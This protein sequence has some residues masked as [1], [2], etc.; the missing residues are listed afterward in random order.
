[1]RIFLCLIM[2]LSSFCAAFAANTPEQAVRDAQRAIDTKNADRF[3]QLVDTKRIAG[4]ATDLLLAE[5]NKTDG[6]LPPMLALI[7]SSVKDSQALTSLRNL[8]TREIHSF[9]H[10]GVLSGNFSGKPD[11]SIRPDGILAPLFGDVSMGRKELHVAGP[12]APNGQKQVLLPVAL[13][14]YGNGNIYPL[15]LRLQWDSPDWQIVE[16]ANL[17]DIW[18]QIQA[19]AKAQQ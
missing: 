11:Q 5:A 12:S 2:L 7:L 9:V 3:E 8:I 14:D 15:L 13:K 1:M 4:A 18:N 19:E 10:Y 17:L 16:I 6:Q